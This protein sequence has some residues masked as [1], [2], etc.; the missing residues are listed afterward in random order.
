MLD[1]PFLGLL[2][3]RQARGILADAFDAGAGQPRV[4][5][6]LV[7]M[8]RGLALLGMANVEQSG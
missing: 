7:E 2:A 4:Q 8:D 1:N 5:S 6:A 3:L